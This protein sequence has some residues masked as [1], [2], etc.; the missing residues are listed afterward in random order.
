M[1]AWVPACAG[2]TAVGGLDLRTVESALVE[3]CYVHFGA[4]NDRRPPTN[5]LL[6]VVPRS[7][8]AAGL[9]VV[10][11]ACS[12]YSRHLPGGWLGPRAEA[13]G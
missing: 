2:M 11:A 4:R 6:G 7:Q 3:R 8:G 1:L 13:R 5:V 10:E 9:A 12:A